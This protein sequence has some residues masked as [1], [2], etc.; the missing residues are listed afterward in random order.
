MTMQHLAMTLVALLLSSPGVSAQQPSDSTKAIV[1]SYLEIHAKL[2]ADKPAEVKGPAK[3]LAAQAAALGKDGEAIARAATAVEA[4]ADIERARDAFGPLSDAVIARV[5]AEGATGF[6]DLRLA[7][8]PMVKR[9]WLQREAQIRN[10]YYGAA[11]LGC[12][13]FK[14]LSK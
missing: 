1:Q 9:S 6:S 2:A 11:M 14:P 3:A 8:C 10:P 5:R 7:Y 13:E 12:G 4:A